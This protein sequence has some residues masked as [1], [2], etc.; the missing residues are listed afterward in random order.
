MLSVKRGIGK[1]YNFLLAIETDAA[2]KFDDVVFKY[3]DQGTWTHRFL[4]TKYRQ[5]SERNKNTAIDLRKETAGD[6]SL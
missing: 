1:K 2:E 4:Q 5:D 6:F 3:G